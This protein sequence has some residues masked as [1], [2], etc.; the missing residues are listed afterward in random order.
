V[1]ET[2]VQGPTILQIQAYSHIKFGS[3]FVSGSSLSHLL[4]ENSAPLFLVH[5]DNRHQITT[6]GSAT[7]VQFGSRYWALSAR[8]Q[9]EQKEVKD[10]GLFAE[11]S[12]HFITSE[13]CI[14]IDAEAGAEVSDLYDV[15]AFEFTSAVQSGVLKADSFTNIL[16]Q[17]FLED[18]DEV[19]M[20]MI[21]GFRSL[22]Q[23]MEWD[24][25]SD[26]GPRMAR[27]HSTKREVLCD[28]EGNSN[29]TSMARFK[30]KDETMLDMD[31]LSGSPAFVVTFLKNSLQYEVKFAGIVLRGSAGILHV[32][33]HT[34][35]RRLLSM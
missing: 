17:C 13:G 14:S 1:S 32:L 30:C 6:R 5:L 18:G 27:I 22:D 23:S 28:Y 3:V 25:D 15:R 24:E 29:E 33:K 9:V 26:L 34:V 2:P 7:L 20:G 8:H 11:H 4:A 21:Y 35:I 16:D 19:T 31:G 12:D 10:V